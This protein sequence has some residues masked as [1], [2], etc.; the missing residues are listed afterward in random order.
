MGPLVGTIAMAG[1]TDV[2]VRGIPAA[3]PQVTT[4]AQTGLDMQPVALA[5]AGIALVLLAL[6]LMLLAGRD[7]HASS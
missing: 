2:T 6:C 3:E 5:C 1:S 7:D 4:L